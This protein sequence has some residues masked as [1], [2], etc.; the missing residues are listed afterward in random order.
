MSD[1]MSENSARCREEAI[2]QLEK[3]MRQAGPHGCYTIPASLNAQDII[4]A[5]DRLFRDSHGC[6]CATKQ[7]EAERIRTFESGATRDRDTDKID[8]E[9]FLSSLVLERFGQYMHKNRKQSDG[10]LRASDNWQKGIPLEAYMKSMW[11]H[12]LDV[13]MC[14]RGE[15]TFTK[16]TGQMEEALCAVIFNASGYLH[17]LLKQ[18]QVFPPA[19]AATD[20]GWSE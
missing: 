9:G 18:P 13:W 5:Y 14:H 12:F 16:E 4:S 19:E 20:I 7:K 10:Q 17:E 6:I 2:A 11:R 8:Y 3:N 15:H 1:A